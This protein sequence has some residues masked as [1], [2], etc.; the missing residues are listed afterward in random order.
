MTGRQRIVDAPHHVW[1]LSVR[2]QEW[3]NG[4]ELAP[5]RRTFILT[6][7]EPEARAVGPDPLDAPST[8]T[9]PPHCLPG[10]GAGSRAHSATS[11]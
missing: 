3:I 4:E 11:P 7:L 2:D 10:S 1:D 9:R 8:G 6:G 5:L